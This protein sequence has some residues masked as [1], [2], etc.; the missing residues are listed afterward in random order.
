MKAWVNVSSTCA[1]FALVSSVVP[2]IP[3]RQMFPFTKS[4]PLFGVKPLSCVRLFATPRT[5][6][7]Q[8]SP[9]FT[10]SWSL[11]RFTSI[12]KTYLFLAM[13][14]FCSCVAG[15]CFRCASGVCSLLW[16]TGFSFGWLF[17]LQNSGSRYSGFTNSSR[18][19]EHG[20]SDCGTWT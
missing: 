20:L 10:V 12:R 11:L 4:L 6:G 8:A 3:H 18:A 19:P 14:G 15:L 2:K 13:L 16:G 9:S 5:A 7:P 17:L 1:E